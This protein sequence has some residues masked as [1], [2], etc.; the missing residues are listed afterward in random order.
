PNPP[1]APPADPGVPMILIGPGTGFAPLRGFLAERAAQAAAG[2]EVAK[3]LLFF[4]CRHPDHDWFCRDAVERWAAAGIVDPYL[5]FSAVASH[6][7]KF[8]QDALWA[9]QDRVWA[10]LQAGAH[11]FLCGDGKFMAPAV[12]DTLIRIQMQQVGDEHAQGSDWLN[13][14]I[15]DGRFHQD[16]F[17]FGK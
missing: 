14:M 1:F 17:G 3:S 4:G 9:E 2:E 5:A 12:R 7:W 11:I 15:E 8:V 13:T 6:P 10:A 16:V